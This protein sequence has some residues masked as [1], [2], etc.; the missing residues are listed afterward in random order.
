MEPE[1]GQGLD[2]L[3]PWQATE[4]TVE[5]ACR[6][7]GTTGTAKRAEIRQP[8][9]TSSRP[10]NTVEVVNAVGSP[11]CLALFA[12]RSDMTWLEQFCERRMREA[13]RLGAD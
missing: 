8:L 6:S 2:N 13:L 11:V 3:K 4:K 9:N 12:N 1:R 10:F 7:A 5:L